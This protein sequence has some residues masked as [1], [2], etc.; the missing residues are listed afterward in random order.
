M[1]DSAQLNEEGATMLPVEKLS[2]N[3]YLRERLRYVQK[4]YKL[5]N[6]SMAEIAGF[7]RSAWH[8][9]LNGTS[10]IGLDLVD[11]F[12][13]YFGYPPEF[14]FPPKDGLAPLEI[15][16]PAPPECICEG[17]AP[18]TKQIVKKFG[19]LSAE[20][21]G[22]LLELM[23]LDSDQ[24]PLLVQLFGLIAPLDQAHKKRLVNAVAAIVA[25]KK[26]PVPP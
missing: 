11:R 6:T 20:Q 17:H 23:N 21:K 14:W 8:R 5:T 10:N 9:L 7:E 25:D 13:A 19:L 22:A 18:L 12:I 1:G 15:K 2:F 26:R 16:V 3:Q 4:A 24:L